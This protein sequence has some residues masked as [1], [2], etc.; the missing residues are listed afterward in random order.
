MMLDPRKDAPRRGALALVGVVA[1]VALVALTVGPLGRCERTA[2]AQEQALPGVATDSLVAPSPG[3]PAPPAVPDLP[4]GSGTNDRV[5]LDRRDIRE[6][7]NHIHAGDN[8]LVKLGEDIEVGPGD[9]VLGDVFAMGGNVTVRGQVDGD[10]VAMGGDVTVEDG[11]QVRGDAVSMGGQ[12]RK[13]QSAIVLGKTVT[14][15][16]FP[17][18]FFAPRT[19]WAVGHGVAFLAHLSRIL[20]WL[21]IG[22][23]VVAVLPA[24]SQRVLTTL[25][26]RVAASFG[27]GILG[28]IAIVP[29]LVG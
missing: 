20:L 2:W 10:V 18:H 6:L 1:V 28:L 8:D 15:G 17:R 23:I 27:W 19:M 9:H 21:L 3:T 24:R 29:A 26:A 22:W 11:A 14:V 4:G 7:R 25:R 5:Q 13:G 16:A 12:V